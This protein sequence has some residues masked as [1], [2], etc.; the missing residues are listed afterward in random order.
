[1]QNILDR[2]NI[3]A[4]YKGLTKA[5]IERKA[6]LPNATFKPTTQT[7]RIDTQSK[8]ITAF[9]DLN[10]AW[11]LTGKGEMLTTDPI[12]QSESKPKQLEFDFNRWMENEEKKTASLQ[13]L[14]TTNSQLSST[15][16]ELVEMLKEAMSK[17]E[18]GEFQNQIDELSRRIDRFF[19]ILESEACRG[20]HIIKG[21][22]FRVYVRI[23][24]GLNVK[25]KKLKS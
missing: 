19:G 18:K 16:R 20:C 5:M 15:N 11:L 6:G 9:P 2:I 1:M 12:P 22:R 3:Y 4:K 25:P 17:G 24:R 14:I 23:V 8:I 21:L 7:I 10:I 13:K